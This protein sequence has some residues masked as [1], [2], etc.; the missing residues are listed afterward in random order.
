MRIFLILFFSSFTLFSQNSILSAGGNITNSGSISFS[1]GQLIVDQNLNNN[2]SISL[3][4]QQPFEI[5]TLSL[6]DI[7]STTNFSAYPNPSSGFFNLQFTNADS[8][9]YQLKIFDIRGRLIKHQTIK[10]TNQ[11]VDISRKASGVYLLQILKAGKQ[12]K[13]FKILK[14]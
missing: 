4:V 1:V 11:S 8:F 2:G 9:P 10:T 13:S 5:M 3:G 6:E 14:N 12:L 7:N